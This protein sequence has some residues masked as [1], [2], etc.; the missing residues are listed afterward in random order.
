MAPWGLPYSRF[1]PDPKPLLTL[2][3]G[4]V[5]GVV[6]PLMAAAVLRRG[7]AWFIAFFCLL[8]NGLYLATAWVSGERNLDTA[9]LLEQ[10][11]H[12]AAILVFCAVTITVGYV[13]FRRQCIR[14]LSTSK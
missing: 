8:A 4:P 3:G 1:D 10:G 14:V 2:W 6:V 5:L 7:W 13:G 11:V 12:P 9:R